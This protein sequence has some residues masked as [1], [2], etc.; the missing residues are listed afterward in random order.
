MHRFLFE[1]HYWWSKRLVNSTND[2]ALSSGKSWLRIVLLVKFLA[3]FKC[4]AFDSASLLIILFWADLWNRLCTFDLR[5]LEFLSWKF[6]WQF[7]ILSW[8]TLALKICIGIS[9]ALSYQ[10]LRILLDLTI[11]IFAWRSLARKLLHIKRSL[12][13]FSSKP[14]SRN[15]RMRNLYSFTTSSTFFS[16]ENF[17]LLPILKTNSHAYVKL[18]NYILLRIKKLHL[19]AP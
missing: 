9:S 14:C 12:I 18:C 10:Q 6:S 8:R 3:K 13:F 7:P 1:V 11:I 19:I 2:R 15:V 16:F 5:G 17:C 4:I